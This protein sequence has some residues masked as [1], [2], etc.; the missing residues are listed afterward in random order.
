MNLFKNKIAT[1]G[2][3]MIMIA[4]VSMI[5]SNWFDFADNLP[6]TIINGVLAAIG[7]VLMLW[8]MKKSG[9]LKNDER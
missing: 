9:E 7:F 8:G 6:V 2:Y 5:A 4:G 3:W 1:I